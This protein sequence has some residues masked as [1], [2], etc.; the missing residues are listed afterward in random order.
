MGADIHVN[1]L[2]N[3]K[4]GWEEVKLYKKDLENDQFHFIDIYPYRNYELFDILSDSDFPCRLLR[5][6]LLPP[7]LKETIEKE[8]RDYGFYNFFEAN[9]ADI[10]NYYYLNPLVPDYDAD[11]PNALKENPIKDFIDTIIN[12]INFWNGWGIEFYSD[13]K[14]VY[15]FDH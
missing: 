3:T 14:I 4:N 13:V 1:I 12:Y 11:D 2:K 6:E 5:T 7:A 8:K 15:R 10:K 9:L